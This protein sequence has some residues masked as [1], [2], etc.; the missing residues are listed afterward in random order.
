LYESW[1]FPEEYSEKG[2]RICALD[3]VCGDGNYRALT[4]KLRPMEI[5]KILISSKTA[6]NSSFSTFLLTL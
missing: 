1:N 4:L 6:F 2:G 5:I 3:A